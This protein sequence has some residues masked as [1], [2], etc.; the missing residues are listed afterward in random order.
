M[1]FLNYFR[2]RIRVKVILPYAILTLVVAIIG[3]YLSTR[4]VSGSLE[5][6][7]TNQLVAAASVAA[8][9]LSQLED[10]QLEDFRAIVFT[11][12]IADAVV[13]GD[14]AQLETLL[15]PLIV[16]KNIDRVDI[17]DQTGDYLFGVRRPAG[18]TDVED[19]VTTDKQSDVNWRNWPVVQ[20]VLNGVVDDLGDKFVTIETVDGELLFFTVGP[21]KQDDE[22][23]GAVLV[24]SQIP[25]V[26]SSL[27]QATFA[28]VSLY[29]LDGDLIDSTFSNQE[30]A[31]QVLNLGQQARLMLAVEGESSF[32]KSIELGSLEYD[33]LY[34]VFRARGNPLGFYSVALQTT[35]IVS[36]GNMARTQM[37]TIFALTLLLVFL[38]GYFTANAIT[39]PVQHLMEDALAVASGDLTR[40]TK[41]SSTDEIGS[42][43]RSLDHMTESLANYT[44]NLQNRISELVLLYENSTA[45]TVKSGLN[46]DHIMQAIA[47]SVKGVI[48]GT[49]QVVVYLLDEQKQQLTPAVSTLEDTHKFATLPFNEKDYFWDL[50]G[51]AKTHLIELEKIKSNSANGYS[52]NETPAHALVVP[53]IASQEIIG[54]LALLPRP[55][56]PD[57]HQLDE[58]KERLLIT[59]A[60]QSAIAIK[61]AQ[62]FDATQRAYEELRQLDDLKTEFINIAAHELRTPLGAMIGYASFLEK[63]VPEKLHKSVRFLT[64]SSLRMRTMVDAMLAIQRLDAGT[65]FL[66]IAS[67]DVTDIIQKTV[68]DFT[69][70]AEMEGHTIEI[71]LAENLPK[72]PADPEK[73]GLILS[74]LISNAIKFT[75]EGGT[76]EV[77]AQDYLKGILIQV[78]DNGVGISEDDQARIF[79]RFYQVRPDHLAGHGGM[80]IGLTIV[81]HLV[82]LHEGQVWVE[83]EEG[84]GTIFSFTLPNEPLTDDTPDQGSTQPEEKSQPVAVVS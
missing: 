37:V 1:W 49:N 17:I 39:K 30:E 12:G 47:E 19:Y 2:S 65:A 75:P 38:I 5:E 57:L 33:V 6:R 64:A 34:N 8:D 26:L 3:V 74:N 71:H 59:L 31:A 78:K 58:D 48:K 32:R 83:S 73:V 42:L 21:L 22:V 29:D 80:G 62:L 76:I 79:E 53:L 11:E 51:E 81:K 4:L 82:E 20:N 13:G 69:P 24:S 7:F 44:Q 41:I 43:A 67:I 35:Y 68:A 25:D 50:F 66:R 36:R 52:G 55:D 45:V 10:N 14:S 16:N 27:R 70:M 28:D 77:S 23:I 61:N 72:V 18:S 54:M 40:R 56:E 63:R 15:F 46:L 60:N 84:E 9:G